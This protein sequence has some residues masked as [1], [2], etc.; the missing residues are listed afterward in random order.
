MAN[1]PPKVGVL[2]GRAGC[3]KTTAL[4][5]LARKHNF[6]DVHI[7]NMDMDGIDSAKDAEHEM[8][9]GVT[10]SEMIRDVAALDREWRRISV[11]KDIPAECQTIVFDSFSLIDLRVIAHVSGVAGACDIGK[12]E[13]KQ[14]GE[15]AQVI[16]AHITKSFDLPYRYVIFTAHERIEKNKEGQMIHCSPSVGS[17]NSKAIGEGALSFIIRMELTH[18]R[19]RTLTCGPHPVIVSKCRSK[20]V[21]A[22]LDSNGT[23]DKPLAD[24]LSLL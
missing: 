20:A 2:Y 5:D 14:W 7:V 10:C 15:R 24:V 18:A 22:I 16:N 12:M 11:R 8:L 19:K 4:A 6:G 21:Q 13:R 23:T 1:I 3:G 9:P 17:E